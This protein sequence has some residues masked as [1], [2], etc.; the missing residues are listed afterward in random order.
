MSLQAHDL[1]ELLKRISDLT[2]RLE[3]L[4]RAQSCRFSVWKRSPRANVLIAV[5]ALSMLVGGTAAATNVTGE[6]LALLQ[7]LDYSTFTV[8]PPALDTVVRW[9]R[10]DVP[11]VAAGYTNVILSLVAEAKQQNSFTWPLY[12]QLTG[13]DNAGA[14]LASSQST[15]VN[16]RAFNRST[17]SPWLASVHSEA[18]HGKDGIAGPSLNTQGT[19]L[20]FNGEL[21]SY[22]STGTAIGLNLQNTPNSTQPGTY[23]INIQ[24][25]S[26]AAVW[27]NGIHFEGPGNGNIGINF[28]QAHYNMGISLGDNSLRMNAGQRFLLEQTGAV[29]LWYNSMASRVELVKS[30]NV[31]A[32]W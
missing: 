22:S 31:V 24:S 32:F 25:T 26:N 1:E 28:D 9:S 18:Y 29:Y 15:G 21:S 27:R 8:S 4:E 14:T 12:I 20:L 17:G 23:A 6:G 2:A 11:N 16:V 19:S 10:S 3:R 5:A 7:V 30:G 13:T